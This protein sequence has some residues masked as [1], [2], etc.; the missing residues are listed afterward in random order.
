MLRMRPS[1]SRRTKALSCNC[2]GFT[3]QGYGSTR[4]F[5]STISAAERDPSDR[6][7]SPRAWPMLLKSPSNRLPSGNNSAP[8]RRTAASCGT[9][10]GHQAAMPGQ[11][12][13]ALNG[14]LCRR[15][16]RGAALLRRPQAAA[17]QETE[18]RDRGT[19]NRLHA[20]WQLS[21]VGLLPARAGMRP[22]RGRREHSGLLVAIVPRPATV[23][24]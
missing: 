10:S 19:Q 11:Q 22:R 7:S 24:A 18:S 8:R 3:D 20:S 9:P 21:G 13:A 6:Q 15:C 16:L 4:V 17:G 12:R 5:P 2:E 14:R 1:L 23:C